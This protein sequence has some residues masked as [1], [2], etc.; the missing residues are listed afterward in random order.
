MK[1]KIAFGEKKQLSKCF[2]AKSVKLNMYVLS[3]LSSLFPLFFLCFF[4]IAQTMHQ[5]RLSEAATV[6]QKVFRGAQARIEFQKVLAKNKAG[7]N[8]KK[9]KKKS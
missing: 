1:S 4:L 3:L 8:G 6:I 2:E 5:Q 9:K 7:K